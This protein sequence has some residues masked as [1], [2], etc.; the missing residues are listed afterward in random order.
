MDSPA[1]A[2][3]PGKSS[4]STGITWWR[5]RLRAKSS[6]ALELSSMWGRA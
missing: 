2:R 4:S 6:E 1:R 3:K 5:T